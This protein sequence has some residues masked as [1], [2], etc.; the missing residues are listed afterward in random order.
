MTE[1]L[2][3]T[4]A[5]GA[6]LA[7]RAGL[8]LLLYVLVLAVVLF[9]PTSHLQTA[10]VNDLVRVLQ[11][12]LPDSWVTFTRVEVLMNAVI[13]APVSLLGSRVWPRLRWQDWT[14]YG[15]VG[16]STV[17]LIQGVLLP[18]RHASFSDI[19]ANTI[20]ALL[21]AVLYRRLR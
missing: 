17:E 12:V 3:R 18:G 20:G 10:L 2:Q 8:P 4:R 1:Q 7:G 21:G 6:G 11:A 16:A 9:S 15:F 13:I 19:V 5:R 14:A